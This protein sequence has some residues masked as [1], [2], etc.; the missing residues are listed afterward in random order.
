MGSL[1]FHPLRCWCACGDLIVIIA[2][3]SGIQP[4]CPIKSSSSCQLSVEKPAPSNIEHQTSLIA[5]AAHSQCTA[6]HTCQHCQHCPASLHMLTCQHS[7][8][9]VAASTTCCQHHT[10]QPTVLLPAPGT[11][12]CVANLL[13][14]L[15]QSALPACID[16]SACIALCICIGLVCSGAGLP[17]ESFSWV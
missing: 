3:R 11:G 1:R 16:M 5:P 12:V 14:A 6:Q 13:P 7:L 2:S 4:P 8:P 15:S 9:A 17:T 10:S